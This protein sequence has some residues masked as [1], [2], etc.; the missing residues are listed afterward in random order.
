MFGAF[1]RPRRDYQGD[2]F[3]K[4]WNHTVYFLYGLCTCGLQ[5]EGLTEKP[6]LCA[7][8]S[9]TRGTLIIWIFILFPD[10]QKLSSPICEKANRECGSRGRILIHLF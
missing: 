3:D 7:R 6:C 1:S 4:Q 9:A 5:F 10:R 8:V 2:C